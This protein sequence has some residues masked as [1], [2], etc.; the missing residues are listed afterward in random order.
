MKIDS[1]CETTFLP[2]MIHAKDVSVLVQLD[3]DDDSGLAHSEESD[4]THFATNDCRFVDHS[5]DE[6]LSLA[7]G[8]RWQRRR[9]MM[10]REGLVGC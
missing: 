3:C 8:P 9:D 6:L 1:S 4:L 7:A 10:G 5:K 2:A